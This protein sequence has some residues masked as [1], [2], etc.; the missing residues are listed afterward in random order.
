[1]A[2]SGARQR[3]ASL[4]V[5]KLIQNRGGTGVEDGELNRGK[6]RR[7]YS[8]NYDSTAG[9]LK[10]WIRAA[11]IHVNFTCNRSR[12][13]WRVAQ[14]VV[15]M[16][17]VYSPRVRAGAPVSTPVRWEELKRP[18]D[19]DAFTIRTIY[20]RLDRVGDLFSTMGEDLQDISP[21]CEALHA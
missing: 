1:M 17:A 19:P 9:G 2:T 5:P 12:I 16:A 13:F 11:F 10:R 21:F 6:G 8:L 20:K 4:I 14:Y 15:T 7:Q 3:V 18:I